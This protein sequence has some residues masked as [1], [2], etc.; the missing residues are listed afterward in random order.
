M[1]LWFKSFGAFL[2]GRIRHPAGA[3]R[4][5]GWVGQELIL[6]KGLQSILA[7]LMQR[8]SASAATMKDNEALPGNFS[9]FKPPITH[10][11]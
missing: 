10:H 7:N 3:Y 4:D 5:V 11:R 8:H 1:E 6:S 9:E 2:C